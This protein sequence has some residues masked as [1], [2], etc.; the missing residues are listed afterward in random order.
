M[1]HITVR[2][3]V[4]GHQA[5]AVAI[6]AEQVISTTLVTG[7]NASLPTLT[8]V[9]RIIGRVGTLGISLTEPDPTRRLAALVNS[10][11]LTVE[12]SNWVDTEIRLAGELPD[13]QLDVASFRTV[14]GIRPIVLQGADAILRTGT[15]VGSPE[16]REK[17]TEFYEALTTVIRGERDVWESWPGRVARFVAS[18]A[19]GPIVTALIGV[20]LL[21]LASHALGGLSPLG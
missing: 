10:H 6:P 11:Y 12:P 4:K 2:L 14:Q 19:L 15:E 5:V 1:S 21:D 9:E 16:R 7:S 17:E 20:P 3:A 18:T 13:Q 8:S